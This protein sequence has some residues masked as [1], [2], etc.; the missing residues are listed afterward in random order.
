VQEA[1]REGLLD[2]LPAPKG[3]S[4]FGTRSRNREREYGGPGDDAGVN[5]LAEQM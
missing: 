1:G 4:G 5:A 3:V 2:K